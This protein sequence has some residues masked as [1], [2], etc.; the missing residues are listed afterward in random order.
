[1]RYAQPTVA[2]V[3]SYCRVQRRREARGTKT[4]QVNTRMA[5]VDHADKGRLLTDMSTNHTQL[6]LSAATLSNDE[7]GTEL[8][9]ERSDGHD[10]EQLS[11]SF[12]PAAP[13]QATER[14]ATEQVVSG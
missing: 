2:S 9:F 11:N 6:C 10:S 8:D 7:T 1:M 14:E 3:K 5:T 13:C 12:V 4:T